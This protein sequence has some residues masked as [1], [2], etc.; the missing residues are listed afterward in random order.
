MS[1]ENKKTAKYEFCVEKQDRADGQQIF[2]YTKIDGY[3][4]TDSLSMDKEK[5]KEWFDKHSKSEISKPK[6][7]V[8]KTVIK[9]VQDEI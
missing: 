2:Y 6:I 5:A 3:C 9:E 8:L 1:N 4:N 7:T